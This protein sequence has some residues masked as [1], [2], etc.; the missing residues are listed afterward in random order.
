MSYLLKVGLGGAVE[1]GQQDYNRVVSIHVKQ[2]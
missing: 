2:R 1:Q